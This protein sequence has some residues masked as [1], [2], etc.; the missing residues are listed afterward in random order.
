[1]SL[2]ENFE[3]YLQEKYA[4]EEKEQNTETDSPNFFSVETNKSSRLGF[5]AHRSSVAILLD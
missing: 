2:R 1:M 4:N 3:T 5:D